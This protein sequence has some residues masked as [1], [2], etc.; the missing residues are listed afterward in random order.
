[1]NRGKLQSRMVDR[2]CQPNHC[3]SEMLALIPEIINKILNNMWQTSIIRLCHYLQGMLDHKEFALYWL[4]RFLLM[5]YFGI[6]HNCP[7]R[8]NSVTKTKVKLLFL[9][10]LCPWGLHSDRGTKMSATTISAMVAIKTLC[11]ESNGQTVQSAN[12]PF[13][14]WKPLGDSLLRLGCQMILKKP[15][16]AQYLV[17]RYAGGC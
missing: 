7:Q 8:M 11:P 13:S 1:M 14:S 12:W 16:P 3:H 4:N 2:G 5:T 9:D 6:T 10:W 17:K 15:I